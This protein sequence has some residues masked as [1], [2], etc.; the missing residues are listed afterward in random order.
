MR[1]MTQGLTPRQGCKAS[2]SLLSL[3]GFAVLWFSPSFGLLMYYNK[4]SLSVIGPVVPVLT[5]APNLTQDYVFWVNGLID[6]GL[7]K[8]WVFWAYPGFFTS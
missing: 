5:T 4:T 3:P 2:S 6:H 8:I 1:K 7:R